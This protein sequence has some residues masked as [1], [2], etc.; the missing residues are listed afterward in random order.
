MRETRS[1]TLL[2]LCLVGGQG[3]YP[4][5]RFGDEDSLTTAGGAAPGAGG[6]GGSVATDGGAD[7]G[8]GAGTPATGG[9]GGEGGV[10][11]TGPTLPCKNGASCDAGEVCCVSHGSAENDACGDAGDCPAQSWEASCAKPSDCPGQVCCYTFSGGA[12]AATPVSIACEDSCDQGAF[13][14]QREVCLTTANC[15]D[16]TSYCKPLDAAP[17]GFSVCGYL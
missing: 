15:S 8:S 17:A 16:T 5:F 1:S 9:S 12:L 7:A 10:A 2:W 4:D 14:N 13:T 11:P 6:N 3:C